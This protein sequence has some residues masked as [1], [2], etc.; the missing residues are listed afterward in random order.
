LHPGAFARWEQLALMRVSR[1]MRDI[2]ALT[3]TAVEPEKIAA[4]DDVET[5][6][7]SA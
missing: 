3:R 7:M 4:E 6:T 5:W 1:D 2:R